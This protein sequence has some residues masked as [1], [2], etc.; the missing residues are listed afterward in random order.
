MGI[1]IVTEDEAVVV[2]VVL[3]NVIVCYREDIEPFDELVATVDLDVMVAHPLHE[4]LLIILTWMH[5]A[6]GQARK[7]G[8][9]EKSLSEHGDL[10]S[11]C[12]SRRQQNIVEMS[13][14]RKEQ[15]SGTGYF[16]EWVDWFGQS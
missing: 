12:R 1:L 7:G 3:L 5:E 4:L 8:K 2:G 9:K 6:V 11:D 10:N 16:K 15:S 14:D 13:A